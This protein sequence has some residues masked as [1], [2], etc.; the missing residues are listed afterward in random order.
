MTGI[1][2]VLVPCCGR[3]QPR[4]VRTNFR[5]EKPDNLLPKFSIVVVWLNNKQ[6]IQKEDADINVNRRNTDNPRFMLVPVV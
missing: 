3:L 6:L 4:Q 1:H 5:T 2:I